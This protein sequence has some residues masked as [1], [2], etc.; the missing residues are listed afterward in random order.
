MNN[1]SYR[2]VNIALQLLKICSAETAEVFIQETPAEGGCIPS[3]MI[4]TDDC[5]VSVSHIDIKPPLLQERRLLIED[6]LP[7]FAGLAYGATSVNAEKEGRQLAFQV[8]ERAG[9]ETETET[10]LFVEPAVDLVVP[11]LNSIQSEFIEL[12][13]LRWEGT[14]TLRSDELKTSFSIQGRKKNRPQGKVLTSTSLFAEI[15]R[16][17]RGMRV[18]V[19]LFQE[20]F[21]LKVEKNDI[22]VYV[23]LFNQG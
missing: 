10:E 11:D 13:F 8:V 2:A 17:F 19:G 23:K 20:A 15:M 3:L 18:K 22:D 7:P 16:I 21:V 14:L 5:L 1:F 4:R 12:H 9:A 6:Q